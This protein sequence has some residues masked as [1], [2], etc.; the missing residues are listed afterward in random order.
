MLHVG[1]IVQFQSPWKEWRA[2]W[3]A[4]N[5]ASEIFTPLGYFFS[6]NSARTVSPVAV[7]VAAIS[8]TMVLKL[9]SG[10]PRQLRVIKENR[11]CSI[12]FYLL[13]PGGRWHTV[14]GMRNSSASACSS[15]FHRRTR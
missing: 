8:C 3:M 5:F 13:V 11:R 12:L 15:I 14:M 6:S 2:S 10:L 1:D 4:A 9:R 7:L